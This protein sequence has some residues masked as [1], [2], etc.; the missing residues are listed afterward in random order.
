[1][2]WVLESVLAL[3]SGLVLVSALE[4]S[5]ASAWAMV[6]EAWAIPLPDSN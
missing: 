3:A 6:A 2:G 1:L 5:M 4:V